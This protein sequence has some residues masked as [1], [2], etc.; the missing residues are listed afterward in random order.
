[1]R[2]IIAQIQNAQ[3]KLNRV[4][5]KSICNETTEH[6]GQKHLKNSQ[7]QKIDNLQINEKLTATIKL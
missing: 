3:C 4:N 7:R 5:E 6:Q 2:D 1:M